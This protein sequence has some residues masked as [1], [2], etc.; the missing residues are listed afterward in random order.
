MPERR[1]FLERASLRRRRL[2]DAARV[3]PVVSAILLM[4]PVWQPEAF[5]RGWGVIL[6]FSFWGALIGLIWLLHRALIRA[7]AA[8]PGAD[9]EGQESEDAL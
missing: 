6:I 8:D 1:L 4:L 2:G 7:G 9:D 3:L 5:A